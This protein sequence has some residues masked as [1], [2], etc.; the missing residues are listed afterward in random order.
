MHFQ[1]GDSGLLG[2]RGVPVNRSGIKFLYHL[3]FPPQANVPVTKSFPENKG[4][5]VGMNWRR[6]E[7]SAATNNSPN[8][9]CQSSKTEQSRDPWHKARGTCLFAKP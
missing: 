6:L 2:I 7:D 5:R 8:P 1:V 4:K 9:D 3:S